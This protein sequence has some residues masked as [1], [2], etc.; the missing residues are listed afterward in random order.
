MSIEVGDGVNVMYNN[1]PNTVDITGHPQLT[2]V[3][4]YDRFTQDGI[5]RLQQFTNVDASDT[6]PAMVFFTD[7]DTVLFSNSNFFRVFFQS[8]LANCPPPPPQCNI[9]TTRANNQLVLLVECFPDTVLGDARI[10]EL[11]GS[12]SFMLDGRDTLSYDSNTLRYRSGSITQEAFQDIRNLYVLEDAQAGGQTGRS[13]SRFIGGT[14][15]IFSGPGTLRVGELDGMGAAFFS[16]S[17][18]ATMEIDTAVVDEQLIFDAMPDNNIVRVSDIFRVG[19]TPPI[20]PNPLVDLGGMEPTPYRVRSF[21]TASRI[22][23]D[24]GDITVLD[25]FGQVLASL[26]DYDSL[27]TFANSRTVTTTSGSSS[28]D[29]GPG[30]LTLYTN[31]NSAGQEQAFGVNGIE[32]ALIQSRIDDAFDQIEAPINQQ[33]RF[34]A[35]GFGD[36]SAVFSA[37]GNEVVTVTD[38][39]PVV[40]G[41]GQFVNFDGMNIEI[42]NQGDPNT[43]VSGSPFTVANFTVYETVTGAPRRYFDEYSSQ[44]MPSQDFAGPGVLYLDNS[45]R[46]FYTNDRGTQQFI[47]GFINS[48]P[49]SQIRTVTREVTTPMNTTVRVVNIEN[50]DRILVEA[51]SSTTTS[52][53]DNQGVIYVGNMVNTVNGFTVPSSSRVV[54]RPSTTPGERI[55][56]VIAPNG[57]VQFSTTTSMYFSRQPGGVPQMVPINSSLAGGGVIYFN[58]NG[59]PVLYNQ[60]T[61]VSPSLV[62]AIEN[63]GISFTSSTSGIAELNF[64]NGQRVINFPGMSST[65]LQGPG[66]IYTSGSQSFYSTDTVRNA[67]IAGEI[68]RLLPAILNVNT[69]TG[70]FQIMSGTGES[71]FNF[72]FGNVRNFNIGGTSTVSYSNGFLVFPGFN[73]ST[74]SFTYY[75]GFET[76]RFGPGDMVSLNGPGLIIR[77]NMENGEIVFIDDR[78]TIDRI[79]ETSNS[80]MNAFRSPILVTPDTLSLTSK[81]STVSAFF[82]QV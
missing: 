12:R 54:D 17:T 41:A 63:T 64:F 76:Q 70:S 15:S 38:S 66:T 13:L 53:S 74:S 33:P 59:G 37:D 65:F 32:S 61:T 6:G 43:P 9:S 78:L 5:F 67:Q 45:N 35:R 21:P 36:G 23:F 58:P 72:T 27:S 24:M 28:T 18:S 4:R 50:N 71:V 3:Q 79:F 56:E 48:L 40:V 42:Y 25:R 52:T 39:A 26:R 49:P 10:M 69:T 7:G 16:T 1:M 57:Q 46:A 68:S 82:G 29:L 73:F 81:N 30:G 19:M 22:E 75:N 80:A 60:D 2:G 44:N 62:M 51:S 34:S 77:I 55:V 14:S 11:T 8:A 20:T 31:E 47:S